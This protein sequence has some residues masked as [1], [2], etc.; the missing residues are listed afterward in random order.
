MNELVGQVG[1]LSF[2][3]TVTRKGT[4]KVETYEM[5]SQATPEQAEALGAKIVTD[6]Q[7]EEK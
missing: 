5:T 4:G 2:T 6:N 3:V 1:K 7:P